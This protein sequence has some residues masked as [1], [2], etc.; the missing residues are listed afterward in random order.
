[1][2]DYP[3]VLERIRILERSVELLKSEVR[4]AEIASLQ[5]WRFTIVVLLHGVI[6]SAFTIFST[7]FSDALVNGWMLGTFLFALV[8]FEA[9]PRAVVDRASRLLLSSLL[10]LWMLYQSKHFSYGMFPEV[11]V[12][13]V[14]IAPFVMLVARWTMAGFRTSLNAPDIMDR[15]MR[16]LS[17]LDFGIA[18]TLF[19]LL[20]ASLRTREPAEFFKPL[21]VMGFAVIPTMI[22]ALML[23]G[24]AA[25]NRWMV[26]ISIVGS[27][28]MILSIASWGVMTAFGSSI[29]DLSWVELDAVDSFFDSMTETSSQQYWSTVVIFATSVVMPC[30]LTL[31]LLRFQGYRLISRSKAKEL[32]LPS[33]K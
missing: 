24:L 19:S 30:I 12:L 20:F 2:D 16:P 5:R 25:T 21:L 31:G 3:E 15:R 13:A 26:R 27:T 33:P 32:S 23:I 8:W 29:H 1:M 10:I 28:I 17:I 6:A 9:S 18:I 7:I 14:F 11:G 22:L 4:P